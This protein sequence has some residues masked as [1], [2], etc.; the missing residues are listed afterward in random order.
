METG[1]S[2]A[3]GPITAYADPYMGRVTHF[4][5]RSVVK[6]PHE[7]ES[8]FIRNADE[9]LSS[10]AMQATVVVSICT[11]H[12]PNPQY[13]TQT[14]IIAAFSMVLTCISVTSHR[15][16]RGSDKSKT[17]KRNHIYVLL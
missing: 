8:N 6:A 7:I 12:I 10:T 9:Q 16:T 13:F 14:H 11:Y 17:N 15:L 1:A 4:V 5:S 3:L 2:Y